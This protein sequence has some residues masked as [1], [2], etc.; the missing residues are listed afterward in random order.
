MNTKGNTQLR[1]ASRK[2]RTGRNLTEAEVRRLNL[3]KHIK[4]MLPE[5][6]LALDEPKAI[7]VL[8]PLSGKARPN[9]D[10]IEILRSD[11]EA[12]ELM[13]A[14]I[15][16]NKRLAWFIVS[17]YLRERGFVMVPNGW[18]SEKQQSASV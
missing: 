18:S 12:L 1:S 9:K 3:L 6:L 13:A 4:K 5:D 7:S 10:D 2:P 16:A 15:L 11:R 17:A 8:V 14:A